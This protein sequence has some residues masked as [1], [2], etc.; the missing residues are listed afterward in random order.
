MKKVYHPLLELIATATES[1]LAK[2]VQYLKE[3]NRILREKLSEQI[4]LTDQERQRLVKF[5]EPLG[6]KLKDVI[7]VVTY[8]TFQRWV[9]KF[10]GKVPSKRKKTG[11]PKT[12]LEI[13]ELVLKLVR[14]TPTVFILLRWIIKFDEHD[15]GVRFRVDGLS[16]EA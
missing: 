11:R 5:G 10:S 3:E 8:R 14:E 2:V 1:E 6:S 16:F 4:S 9:A 7:T 13:Q 12:S 15:N